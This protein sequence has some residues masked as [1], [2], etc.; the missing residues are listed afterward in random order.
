QQAMQDPE[1]RQ[2]ML[3]EFRNNPQHMNQMMET[4]MTDSQMRQQMMD[5]MLQHP[6]MMSSMKQHKPMMMHMMDG[7][8]MTGVMSGSSP[9][10]GQG[11]K[12]NNMMIGSDMTG[13]S[14][15]IMKQQTR[16]QIGIMLQDPELKQQMRDL[17]L[18]NIDASDTTIKNEILATGQS[19]DGTVLVEIKS[20]TPMPGKFLELIETFHDK[21]GNILEHVNHSI[22]VTQ[23]DQTVL[24]M[25]DLHSHHGEITYYTR[26]LHSDSPVEIEI[27]MNGIGMEEP[28]IGPT[29]EVI[30]VK[31]S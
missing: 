15:Q 17:V 10:M 27:L 23:D 22:H 25:S 1:F 30:A 6:N 8:D 26:E 16:N 7:S 14:Q 29:D 18:Q 3:N 2:N 13:N 19:S 5:I 12:G 11:M 20:S 4:M 28:L 31:V 24:K 9:M 21:D